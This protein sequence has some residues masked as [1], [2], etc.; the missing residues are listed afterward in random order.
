[1]PRPSTAV[2]VAGA[3][4][5]VALAGTAAADPV[6]RIAAKF[7]KAD[8]KRIVKVL[9][10]NSLTGTQINEAKLRLPKQA[11]AGLADRALSADRA[12]TADSAAAAGSAASADLLDG[13]DSTHFAEAAQLKFAVV[14]AAGNLVRQRGGAVGADVV[15]LANDTYRVTWSTDVSQCSFTATPVGAAAGATLAVESSDNVNSIRVDADNPTA[16]HL[17]VVC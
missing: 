10:R 3:A 16:F 8:G 5:V 15:N 14:D 1:M 4:V 13:R 12:V 9:P 2:L 7:T 6:A 17:Q 11:T